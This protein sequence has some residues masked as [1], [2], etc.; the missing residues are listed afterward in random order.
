MDDGGLT[1]TICE[2]DSPLASAPLVE[3]CCACDEAKYEVIFEGLWSRHTHPKDFPVDEWQTQ[4][5]HLIGASH[6]IDYDLWKYGELASPAL[7]ML[8]VTGQTKKLEIDMKRSSKNI[9]SVIKARG[10]NQRSNV[11]GRSFAVFRTDSTNHL[12]SLVSK[13][14]PSPD[15]IV[16]LSL[17]NLCLTNCSWVDSRIIDLDPWDAGINSGVTYQNPGEE[18]MPREAI[19]RITSCNPDD[20]RSPFYDPTCAPLKPVARLHILKQREYKK[21]CPNSGGPAGGMPLN[22]SWGT[23]TAGQINGGGNGAPEEDIYSGT[24]IGPTK[25]EEAGGLDYGSA[26]SGTYN[27]YGSSYSS[28]SS[29]SYS[30]SSS[31]SYKDSSNPCQVGSVGYSLL[32]GQGNTIIAL[33]I[34]KVKTYFSLKNKVFILG[35]LLYTVWI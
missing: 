16:G 30:G 18:T 11:V 6:S 9:R 8:A 31:S 24:G 33:K 12:L 17:E 22:P 27:D 7:T 21:Q 1:Y 25:M 2:D 23:P 13:I 32:I 3:P 5:S 35:N 29:S 15:W 28:S 19:H 4:F 20:E 26:G 34:I 14:I 10:L